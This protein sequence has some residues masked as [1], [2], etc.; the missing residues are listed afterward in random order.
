MGLPT[1]GTS[2]HMKPSTAPVCPCGQEN[3]SIKINAACAQHPSL[4]HPRLVMGQG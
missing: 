3:E 2:H 1:P 4:G